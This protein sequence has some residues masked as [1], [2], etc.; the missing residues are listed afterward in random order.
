MSRRKPFTVESVSTFLQSRGFSVLESTE[1]DFHNLVDG[2][3]KL[4]HSVAVNVS[5]E[6]D[7]VYVSAM[8]KNNCFSFYDCHGIGCEEDLVEDVLDAFAE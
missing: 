3:L 8:D 5:L 4:S 2:E 7:Y 6:G 1:P